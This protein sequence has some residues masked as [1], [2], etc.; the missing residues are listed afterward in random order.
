MKLIPVKTPTSLKTLYPG[1][2]WD[3]YSK[4]TKTIYL[5][6]DD[7]PVPEVTEF[8]LHQLKKFNALATFFCIG[9]NIQKHPDI[10]NQLIADGHAIGN[11]TM[12]HL[13][14]WENDQAHY[15]QNVIACEQAIMKQ[16]DI[17]S[18]LFRPPYGQI[19]TSKLRAI[20]EY[21]YKIILWDILAKDWN[22]NTSRE[23]CTKNVI[24]YSKNG[25]IVV[26]HDSIKAFEN[27]KFALPR[28][29]YHFTEKGYVFN[30]IENS[31]F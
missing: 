17:K 31:N 8:V 29:L 14:A 5:T 3:F 28:I 24:N 16:T 23:A 26:L 27:L 1:Y 6:F 2:H 19:S 30:R 11:H 15:I 25:S 9:E 12:N 7:G 10:F 22:P 18:K 4:S 21:G 13:K 20:K